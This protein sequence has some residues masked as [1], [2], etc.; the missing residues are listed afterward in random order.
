MNTFQPLQGH[1]ISTRGRQEDLDDG[2]ARVVALSGQQVDLVADLV[3]HAVKPGGQ[4]FY[5]KIFIASF[6]VCKY[7]FPMLSHFQMFYEWL[8]ILVV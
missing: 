8:V 3:A 2:F 5:F 6:F 4:S 7:K 1:L